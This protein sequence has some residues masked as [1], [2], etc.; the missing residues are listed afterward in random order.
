MEFANQ[1]PFV[2]APYAGKEYFCDRVTETKRICDDLLNG[3]NVTL[4]S[5]RR[6]GKSG[7]IYRVLEELR[8]NHKSIETFYVD[9]YACQNLKDFI[10]A[11][12]TSIVQTLES[13]SIAQKFIN[14]IRGVRPTIS[15]DPMSG[16]P[17]LSITYQNNA[18]KQMTLKSIFDYLGSQKKQIVVAIDEFQQIR[19]FTEKNMEALLR[20]FIQPLNNVRFIFSGSRQHLM[21]DMFTNAKS[22]FYE[23]TSRLHLG[24]I[25]REVY[26]KF[27]KKLFAQNKRCIDE[28]SLDF[29]M[30]WTRGHTYYTQFLCN[31]LFIMGYKKIGVE[32]VRET[33]NTIL[34]ENETDFLERRNMLTTA[35]WNYLIAVAKEESVSQPTSGEFLMKYKIGQPGNSRRLLKALLDKEL[36]LESNTQ[37]GKTYCV[38]NVFL[39]RWMEGL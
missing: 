16:A 28:A 24:K 12:S 30:D 22:P 14:A 39:S 18:E 25:E 9:V 15:F 3:V 32:Q 2:L 29:V 26:K 5:P 38:Y 6:Y 1:N 35:Q 27:I 10:A 34:K 33:A 11:F 17:Q 19:N 21:T 7:L 8:E 20:T 23:S 4:I 36:I 31:R 37:E 13:E